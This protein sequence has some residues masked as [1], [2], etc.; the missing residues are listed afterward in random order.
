MLSNGSDGGMMV[1]EPTLV[2]IEPA[3]T[4]KFVPSNT[5]PRASRTRCRTARLPMRFDAACLAFFATRSRIG[6]DLHGLGQS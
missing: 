3:D 2:K 1:F 6:A 5:M 4:V